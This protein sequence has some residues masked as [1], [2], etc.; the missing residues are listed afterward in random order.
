L[1]PNSGED[2]HFCFWVVREVIITTTRFRW[3]PSI[4]RGFLHRSTLTT[5]RPLQAA[6]RD[7]DA[8]FTDSELMN[9]IKLAESELSSGKSFT[10]LE[11]PNLPLAEITLFEVLPEDFEW[12]PF[13]HT[14]ASVPHLHS[15][16]PQS[17]PY[18]AGVQYCA[19]VK[20][21]SFFLL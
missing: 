18:A 12:N 4:S 15:A 14:N 7:L 11:H 3:L 17:R 8:E 10:S 6:N 5:E 13:V 2:I 1:V 21:L 16:R 9:I 20:P 19:S